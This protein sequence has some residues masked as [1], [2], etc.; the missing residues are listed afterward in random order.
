MATSAVRKVSEKVKEGV[1]GMVYDKKVADLQRDTA[2]VQGSSGITTD[3]GTKVHDVDHWARVVD[4][5]HTG[6]ALLEDQIARERVRTN[7]GSNLY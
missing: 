3:H 7:T 2:E 1:Q 5:R 4:E 6:P